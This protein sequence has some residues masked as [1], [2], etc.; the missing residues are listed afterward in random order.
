M[1]ATAIARARAT[2]IARATATRARR[3][4]RTTTRAGVEEETNFAPIDATSSDAP[5]GV[6]D[7]RFGPEA[8][9][10]VG[11]T[12]SEVARWRE[13]LDEIGADFVRATACEEA[14]LDAP[15][16]RALERLPREDASAAKL[17]LGVP[18]MM[19]LSGMSSAEVMEIVDV[20]DELEWEPCVFA[21][22]VPKNYETNV[23]ALLAEIMD[24]HERL[25]GE[26]RCNL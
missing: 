19:F 14:T 15:L 24:D 20:Y 2:A 11:F 7:G 22:A 18:R 5:G 13:T 8:T 3:A 26:A 25:T 4:R 10:L 6:A 16:G 23:R 9:L 1:R 17:A 12:E 21:C